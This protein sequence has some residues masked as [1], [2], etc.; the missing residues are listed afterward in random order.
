[1]SLASLNPRAFLIFKRLGTRPGRIGLGGLLGDVRFTV[2]G[3]EIFLPFTCSIVLAVLA[4]LSVLSVP[5]AG[6][7]HML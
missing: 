5:A 6:V 7:S 4:V 3:R 1:M 2:F